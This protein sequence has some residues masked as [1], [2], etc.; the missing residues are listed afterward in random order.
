MSLEKSMKIQD[1][2]LWDTGLLKTNEGKILYPKQRQETSS[3]ERQPPNMEF[4]GAAL[5]EWDMQARTFECSSSF[6]KYSMSMV[7]P[8][9]LLRGICPVEMIH[10]DD[11]LQ[12]QEFFANANHGESKAEAT[13]RLRMLDGSCRCSRIVG[14]F[15]RDEAGTLIRVTGAITDVDAET[16]KAIMVES[17]LNALPGGIA[18]I[19]T[20]SDPHISF[21]SEGFV[22]LA[23]WSRDELEELNKNGVLLK[24]FMLE[25]DY[26]NF[27]LELQEASASGRAINCTYRYRYKS[28]EIGWV[29]VAATKIREV[30]IAPVYYA[31][32][33]KPTEETL[34]YRTMVDDS[35][36]AIMVAEKIS[37]TIL[38]VNKA[39][40]TL[41]KLPE[42]ERPTG[43]TLS[44]LVPQEDIFLSQETLAS[45]SEDSFATF[46]ATRA[47]GIFL[48]I[49]A[50]SIIWNGTPSYILYI[51]DETAE[52]THRE[53]LQNLLD[54][55]PGGVGIFELYKET[56]SLKYINDG[57]Y[58]ILNAERGARRG[59]AGTNVLGAVHPEDRGLVVRQVINLNAGAATFDTSVRLVSGDGEYIWMRV[60]GVVVEKIEERLIIYC[61]FSNIDNLMKLQNDLRYHRTLLSAAMEAANIGVWELDGDKLCIVRKELAKSGLSVNTIIHDVPETLITRGNIHPD[62]AES[63]RELYANVQD[64]IRCEAELQIRETSNEPYRWKQTICTPFLDAGG[65]IFKTIGTTIDITAQKER[66]KKYQDQLNLRRALARN[67]IAM[68][69]INL[70]RD[71]VEEC[72]WRSSDV[73]SFDGTA[74]ELMEQFYTYIPSG[75]GLEEYRAVFN[76]H[77]MLCAYHRGDF[78]KAVRHQL[79]NYS[80]WIE[81]SY[82][83]VSNPYTGEIEAF[84][85]ARDVT[86]AIRAEQ[87]VNTLVN[88]DYDFIYTLDAKTGRS[89]TFMRNERSEILG[90]CA[91]CADNV[92]DYLERYCV[93]QD[94]QS[95]INENRMEY[96]KERLAEL[97]IHISVFSIIEKGMVCHKRAMYCYLDGDSDT[98]LCAVQDYTESHQQEE[99][100]KR[101]LEA[102]LSEAKRADA[103]KTEFLSNMSHE[104]RT[105]INAIIGLTTLAE[106]DLFSDANTVRSYLKQ[107]GQSSAYL[108]GIINDI[109]DMSRIERDKFELKYE[110][111]APQEIYDSCVEMI[112]PQM[113]EKGIIFTYPSTLELP[114]EVEVYADVL[115]SKQMLMNLLNNALKFTKPGGTIKLDVRHTN[116][117][118]SNGIDYITVTDTGC[119][120]SEDFLKRIFEPFAQ[121]RNNLTGYVQGT[122]LGLALSQKIAAAM[123][124]AISV[125]SKLGKGSSFTITYPYRYRTGKRCSARTADEVYDEEM[126]KGAYVLLVEDHPLNAAIASKLLERKGVRIDRAENGR[127]ALE[128]FASSVPGSYDAVL[129]DIRMPVMGGIDAARALRKQSRSDAAQIPVIA[130][131]ANAFEEDVRCTRAAGMNAHLSKPIEPDKLYSTLSKYITEYRSIQKKNQRTR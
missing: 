39:W 42:G 28:G 8:D 16:E 65:K 1:N 34:L 35:D 18:I 26:E 15:I 123:G 126:L 50:K 91:G 20:G 70:S 49:H 76:S 53:R 36:T 131:T 44:S 117:G 25:E 130:M 19:N 129:M 88:T 67:S 7:A 82:D 56:I 116:V 5:F 45:L 111:A 77:A 92:V 10:P 75:C 79:K 96:I 115:R 74:A 128:K 102:A 109:L 59:Y 118:E 94:K 78:H 60:V 86:E 114:K 119:G 58:R 83:L 6:Y 84:C 48:N 46:H 122:G 37:G 73:K 66:E 27:C 63:A 43:R 98:I 93:E 71:T 9:A 90:C 107:I 52:R 61:T 121:E 124:G 22:K 14:L 17:L 51:S 85:I 106:S 72:I 13:L 80:G 127:D 68:A 55:V 69:A 12:L 89:V 101:R 47:D 38:F 41:E 32:F 125:D 21:F 95:I 100:Q 24:T 4:C 64:G 113:K 103:A 104:I 40:L 62:S 110:W 57:Y 99:R 97:D 2:A 87:V 54:K 11:I 105:P 33:T 108:L 29:H 81:S 112:A 23:D 31:I 30:G 120:M 3:L